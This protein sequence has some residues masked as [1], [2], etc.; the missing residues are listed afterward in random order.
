MVRNP[1][2][3]HPGEDDFVFLLSS[4]YNRQAAAEPYTRRW[5]IEVTFCHLKS[6]GLRLEDLRLEGK[7]KREVML[8]ILNLIFVLCVIE[9]RKFYH[10]HARSQ[11][12]K[13]DSRSGKRTL[14]HAILR[15]GLCRVLATLTTLAELLRRLSQIYRREPPPDWAFV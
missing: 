6:N 7:Q 1:K 3:G 4:W 11:Q 14:V 10:R 2:A 5:P 8:A 12:T 9:G 13:R 15:Q